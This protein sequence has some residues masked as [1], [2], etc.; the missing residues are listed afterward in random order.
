M[1]RYKLTKTW[2]LL[3]VT[4]CILMSGCGETTAEPIADTVN[5]DPETTEPMISENETTGAEADPPKATDVIFADV[6]LEYYVP[7]TDPEHSFCLL[8][9]GAKLP[10]QMQTGNTCWANSAVTSLESSRYLQTGESITLNPMDIVNN[11]YFVTNEDEDRGEG[12]YVTQGE[13]SSYG[14][15]CELIL[16]T[17]STKPIDGYLL[18]DIYA[19][20]MGDVESNKK[21]IRELGAINTST[22]HNQGFF[23]IPFHGYK[24]Q[25]YKGENPDHIV[26]LVGWDDDFPAEA[27]SPAA[28]QNGAWLAQNSLSTNWGNNGYYWI[29]YDSAL[30]GVVYI[31]TDQYRYA[32][33]YGTYPVE[34]LD[35]EASEA[36]YAAVYEI[37]GSLGAIGILSGVD[38]TD[39]SYT[40]E[41]LDGEFGEV[42]LTF[43]GS[44]EMTG[45]HIAELPKALEV[46]TCTVVVHKH[47]NIPVEGE[48]TEDAAVTSIQPG[49]VEYVAKSEPGR[50]FVLIG[51]KW[52][53][54]SSEEIRDTL[55]LDYIPGDLFLPVLYN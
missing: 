10:V 28:G 37:N 40:I 23:P 53:D 29:S 6:E 45:Y 13:P 19:N 34:V 26:T 27:F 3:G 15:G 49:K 39:L 31:P 5:A 52:M 22:H 35:T 47:R 50:C 16:A 14:G 12:L 20:Y 7:F 17:M 30:S 38:E 36:V 21:M 9:E 33:N 43:S 4:G 41:I 25:N 2:I 42:L 18:S 54:T 48:S 24:T 46:G 51:D 44:E 1:H 55:E 8:N 11:I 32:Q